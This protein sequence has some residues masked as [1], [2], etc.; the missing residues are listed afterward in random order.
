[1]SRVRFLM[2][3]M[4]AMTIAF[5]L[6]LVGI[7][8]L[9]PDLRAPA[10]HHAAVDPRAAF[11]AAFAE[12]HAHAT[13]ERHHHAA[14]EAVILD[15][16]DRHHEHE[17]EDSLTKRSAGFS[18]DALLPG[19]SPNRVQPVTGVARGANAAKLDP[20]YIGRLERPPKSVDRIGSLKG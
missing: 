19:K 20:L 7:T 1:M 5:A 4:I 14:D 2:R 17:L 10:H 11:D 8:T 12:M 13:S 18:G 9:I 15:E 16:A 6:P 3:G